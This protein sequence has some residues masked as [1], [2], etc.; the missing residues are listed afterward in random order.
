MFDGENCLWETDKHDIHVYNVQVL[1]LIS[2]VQPHPYPN[3]N[4]IHTEPPTCSGGKTEAINMYVKYAGYVCKLAV[5][6]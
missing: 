1:D 5:I 2:K 6:G 4:P 3:P